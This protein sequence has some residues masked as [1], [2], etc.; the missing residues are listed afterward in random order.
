MRHR[1]ITLLLAVSLLAPGPFLSAKDHPLFAKGVAYLWIGDKDL[2]RQNWNSYF[3]TFQDPSLRGAFIDL[4]EQGDLWQ[5]TKR[6]NAYLDIN[7]RST[8]ALVGIALATSDMKLSTSI[9]NLNRAINMDPSFS[10]AYVCLGMEYIKRKNFPLGKSYINRGL[11]NLNVPEYKIL[12]AKLD[13]QSNQPEAALN[14]L[15]PEAD[16]QPDNFYFNFFTA[17][18][19]FRLGRWDDMEKYIRI[20]LELNPSNLE[21]KLLMAKFFFNKDDPK[22]A[23]GVLNTVKPDKYNADYNNIYA[24]VLLKQKDN[25]CK[26]Y[27]DEIYVKDRWDKDVN[28]LLGLYHLWKKQGNP[29]VQNWINRSIL[30]GNPVSLLQQSFPSGYDFPQYPNLPFFEIKA[31]VWLSDELLVVGAVKESGEAGKLFFIDPND[32]KIVNVIGFSGELQDFF[33]SPDRKK[34]IFS[35]SAVLNQSVYIY[36]VEVSDSSPRMVLVSPRALPMPA[37]EVG[38]NYSGSLAYI[39]DRRISKLAFESPFSMVSDIGKKTPVYPSYPFPIYKYNFTSRSMDTLDINDIKELG[40][41][42]IESVKKYYM[43]YE[44]YGSKSPIQSLMEK[45]KSLDLTSSE[46]VKIY[47]AYDLSAFVIYLSDLKNAFQAL[48]FEYNN[49]QLYNTD[50]TLFIGAGNYA[51]II[52]KDFN[53]ENK[54]ILALTSDKEKRLIAYNYQT[55]LSLELADKVIESYFDR[56]FGLHYILTERSEKSLFSETNLEIVSRAP[57]FREVVGSRRDLNQVLFTTADNQVYFTSF[58]GEVLM[59]DGEH[60]FFYVGPSVEGSLYAISPGHKKTAAFI[61]ERLYFLD[62]LYSPGLKAN[63]PKSR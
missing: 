48:I 47:F 20:A 3:E 57:F 14:A 12:L 10:S 13:L 54:E 25:K 19:Y 56:N 29:N 31:M 55:F 59:M 4:L 2:A 50:E 41:V 17:E 61:N 43:V 15:K 30:S 38:F 8:P 46:I 9:D 58:N 42:P 37:V 52:L 22:A 1:I 35:T 16:R 40:Q 45:G 34:F 63:V 44:A 51:E 6:F 21:A 23:Q 7:H 28:R 33:L 32:L 39:T 5:V 26:T 36:A 53:P 49:N 62:S 24:Q 27:L 11:M 60:K 18:A